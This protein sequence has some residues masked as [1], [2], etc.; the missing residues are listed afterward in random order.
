[1]RVERKGN[2]IVIIRNAKPMALRRTKSC[3]LLSGTCLFWSNEYDKNYSFINLGGPGRDADVKR[4]AGIA[5]PD[6]GGSTGLE[7]EANREAR[8]TAAKGSAYTSYNSK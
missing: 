6:H 2:R 1:M 7:T 8:L 5:K 4:S 3:I